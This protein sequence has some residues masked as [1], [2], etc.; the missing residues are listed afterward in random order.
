MTAGIVLVVGKSLRHK[1]T[2]AFTRPEDG[3][4]W[5]WFG[6][7]EAV[8]RR[9]EESLSV[10]SQREESLSWSCSLYDGNHYHPRLPFLR[11]SIRNSIRSFD[12]QQK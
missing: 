7:E 4:E 8:G 2:N 3:S 9:L 1:Q 10:D 12:S 11:N 6:R 5:S